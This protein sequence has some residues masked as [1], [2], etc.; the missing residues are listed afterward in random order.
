MAKS[1]GPAGP[2]VMRRLSPRDIMG[3]QIKTLV[4]EET[5][6]VKLYTI[7]GVAT[8]T[9]TKDTSYGES[10]AVTGQFECV[11]L[12]DGVI[13]RGAVLYL[14]EPAGSTL[15]EA[16]KGRTSDDR[17]VEFIA[18]IGVKPSKK[19]ALGYEYTWQPHLKP[20]EKAALDNLRGQVQGLLGHDD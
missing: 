3:A 20:E 4:S 5:G 18:T 12:F 9:R 10:T 14:P 13:M 2:E 15:V 1:K 11:R 8:G 6:P 17:G 7:Y 16:V 19:S